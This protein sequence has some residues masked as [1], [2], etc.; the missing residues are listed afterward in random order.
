MTIS[1][2]VTVVVNSNEGTSAT[3]LI[4]VVGISVSASSSDL[5][6]IY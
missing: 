4:R 2:V 3:D 1:L 5:K 6:N